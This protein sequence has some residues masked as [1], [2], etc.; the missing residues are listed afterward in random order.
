VAQEPERRRRLL[1]RT[2]QL[3]KGLGALGLDTGSGRSHS[4]PLV[5]GGSQAAV[6]LCE[7][8]LAR[9]IFAQA[10]RHPSVP[11]GTARLRLTPSCAHTETDITR[12]IEVLGELA[13]RPGA[14]A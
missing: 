7:S 13:P 10:I 12:C 1:E 5:V 11:D 2:E 3:R 6:D 9:G 4:V 8:A 14:R